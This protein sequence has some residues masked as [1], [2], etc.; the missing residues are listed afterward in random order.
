MRENIFKYDYITN[1]VPGK[2]FC[3]IIFGLEDAQNVPNMH[4]I[5][6]R[7]QPEVKYWNKTETAT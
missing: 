1:I 7:A 6:P 2:Y 4:Y 5:F 3:A